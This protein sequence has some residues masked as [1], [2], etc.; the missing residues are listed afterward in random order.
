MKAGKKKRVKI[1]SKLGFFSLEN[2][3]VNSEFVQN[4][5]ERQNGTM[6]QLRTAP[7]IDFVL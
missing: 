7:A 4:I 2:K 5:A 1:N 6:V 3:Q